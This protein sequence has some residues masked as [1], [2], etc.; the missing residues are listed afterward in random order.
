[1]GENCY[2]MKPG[3]SRS[4]SNLAKSEHCFFFFFTMT[5]EKCDIFLKE[6]HETEYYKKIAPSCYTVSLLCSC[7]LCSQPV[8]PLYMFSSFL[9]EN[10]VIRLT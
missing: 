8:C 9:Y 2:V 4:R 5:I 10:S 7:K 3:G 6:I 1:M